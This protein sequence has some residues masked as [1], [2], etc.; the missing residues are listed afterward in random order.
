MIERGAFAYSN[1]Y[2]TQ[3]SI[4]CKAVH[5]NK[6]ITH[7]MYIL[8]RIGTRHTT[9]YLLHVTIRESYKDDYHFIYNKDL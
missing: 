8:L 1:R 7:T 5:D 6:N 4:T 2:V 9:V 3:Y